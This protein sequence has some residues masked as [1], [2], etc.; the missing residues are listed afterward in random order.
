MA[1]DYGGK[2]A[3][4]FVLQKDFDELNAHPSDTEDLVN[5]VLVAIEAAKVS[6]SGRDAAE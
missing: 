6:R 2:L 1:V 5:D 3:H 4:T